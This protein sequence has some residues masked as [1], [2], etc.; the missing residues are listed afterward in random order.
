MGLAR[1]RLC[2]PTASQPRSRLR[3]RIERARPTPN[4]LPR[5]SWPDRG[6]RH[7][8]AMT[9]GARERLARSPFPAPAA[10]SADDGGGQLAVSEIHD[11]YAFAGA[12]LEHKA[13]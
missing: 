7:G 3:N 2:G 8:T 5:P 13:K 10:S 11:I 4:A 1:T 9:A 6:R 12:V